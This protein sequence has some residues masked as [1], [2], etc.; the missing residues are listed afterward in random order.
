MQRF[1]QSLI[2]HQL[3][4]QDQLQG[5]RMGLMNIIIGPCISLTHANRRAGDP[6]VEVIL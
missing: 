6:T 3:L 2:R 5:D 4:L 1:S